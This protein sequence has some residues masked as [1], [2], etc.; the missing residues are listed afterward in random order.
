V[1]RVGFPGHGEDSESGREIPAARSR[2]TPGSPASWPASASHAAA[3]TARHHAMRTSRVALASR[4]K[5]SPWH[6]RRAEAHEIAPTQLVERTK[7]IV[8]IR[9]PLSVF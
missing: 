7:Q 3:L 4:S 2:R 5:R 8:L 6:A 1:V 9:H